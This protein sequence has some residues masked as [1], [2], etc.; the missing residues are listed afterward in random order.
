MLFDLVDHDLLGEEVGADRRLVLVAEALVDVLV[1][2][3]RLAYSVVGEGLVS[4]G[5]RVGWVGGETDP[6]SPRMMTC[7]VSMVSTR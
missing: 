5:W 2:E 3:G 6:E 1:H 7:V 4:N